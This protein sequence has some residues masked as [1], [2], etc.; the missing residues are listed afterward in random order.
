MSSP[1][2][3]RGLSLAVLVGPV[4]VAGPCL[5][6][7]VPTQLEDIVV[8]GRAL[9]DAVGQFVDEVIAAPRDRGPA[10]WASR[11]C[12]GVVNLRLEAA[13]VI[14]DR[15]GMLAAEAGLVAGQPGCR[16]SILV[17]ATDD[18]P[19][20]AQAMTSSYPRMFNPGYA[21]ATRGSA[22]L[23]RFQS[24]EDAIRWWHISV[25]V[26]S[27]TGDIAVR[28][29]GDPP[30]LVRQDASRLRT[31]IR[32]DLTAVL[33]VLDVNGAV[34][35]SFQQIGDYIGMIALAQVDPEAD[36]LSNDTILNVFEP[37]RA[38]D[39]ATEWDRSFLVSLYAAELNQRGPNSQTGEI[40]SIMLRDRSVAQQGP[41][42]AAPER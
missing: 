15:V 21:G 18:G 38:V 39:A 14:A 27:D 16:P 12:V 35:L 36:V 5:A 10:R 29:P 6:Q 26:E 31:R 42:E 11:V 34:G 32:N 30:P 9:P 41:D 2:W 19:A 8:E 7:A 20:L 13:Q 22:A 4:L 1:L 28:L 33:I 24:S 37:G 40:S 17:M 23:E 25:P 3:P